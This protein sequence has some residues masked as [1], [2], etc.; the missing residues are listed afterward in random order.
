VP[1]ARELG[2][3]MTALRKAN[4]VRIG[5]ARLKQKLRD[6]DARIGRILAAPPE[7][8]CTATVLELLLAVPTIGPVRA[9]RL[10]TAAR[11]S[12][13]KIIGAL[14]ERQRVQLIDL[15]RNRGEGCSGPL[16]AG[17]AIRP[18]TVTT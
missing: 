17:A 16:N 6:G 14:T 10:L 13:S 1:A 7:C 15:L 9:G 3:R 18:T 8:V 5:R 2:R 11:V 12:Q 4:E